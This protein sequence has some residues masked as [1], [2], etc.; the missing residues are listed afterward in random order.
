MRKIPWNQ[1]EAALLIDTYIQIC[2]GTVPKQAAVD[3]LSDKLRKY[4]GNTRPDIDDTYRNGS[5]I[6]MRMSEIAFLFDNGT[7]GLKKT[8]KLFSEMVNLYKGDKARFDAILMEAKRMMDLDHSNK[9]ASFEWIETQRKV[10]ASPKRS[11]GALDEAELMD[12]IKAFNRG[13]SFDGIRANYPDIRP[14]VLKLMLNADAI[15]PI[16]NKYYHR[17]NIEDWGEAADCILA[18]VRAQFRQNGGYTSAKMLHDELHARLEDFFFDNGGFDSQVELYDLTRY[19]FEKIRYKGYA[20]VFADNKHIWET[21]PD[22]SRTYLG[23][24]AH[25]A[26]MQNRIM[27]RDEMIDK[28]T[29]LGSTSAKATFS[30]L[31]HDKKQNPAEKLF[32]MYD[33]YRYV[34]T[35]ACRIDGTFLRTLRMELEELFDGDD[36]LPFEDIDD[37]FYTTLPELPDGVSWSPYMIRSVLAF[38]DVGFF[39]VAAGADNDTKI[40]DAAIV[41]KDSNYRTFSDVLWAE[42]NRDYELPREFSAEE[43]RKIL[44]WKGFIHEREKL[45]N[46]HSVVEGDLRYL[47]TEGNRKVTV[48]K[49]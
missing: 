13:V 41:R 19:L 25:F 43:F 27:T 36:Y 20:F 3:Y 21:A 7:G 46:V 22:Y 15:V 10:D 40:L 35:E 42:L 23:I 45:Y 44:L 48:S 49:K 29:D 8:S 9:G 30:Y 6:R 39:T 37:F 16:N 34:L 26:G 4:G 32:L 2:D 31:M 17:D 33:E 38:F 12:F 1:Y 18:A 47:W 11:T 28:L 14:G 24:L 5:G